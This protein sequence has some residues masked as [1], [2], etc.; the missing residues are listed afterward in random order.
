MPIYEYKCREC[1]ETS[2]YRIT[3][4]SQANSVACKN[5]GSNK[6]DKKISAP[7]ISTGNSE[8]TGQTCCGRTHRCS[9]AGG[10]CGH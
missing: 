3:S 2:E 10:C 1:G 9:D 6:L 5:C 7:V 8:P 4:Q